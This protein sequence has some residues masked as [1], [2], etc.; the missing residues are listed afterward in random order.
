MMQFAVYWD[1]RIVM[2]VLTRRAKF[3]LL[4]FLI[5]HARFGMALATR[6][7]DTFGILTFFMNMFISTH[8]KIMAI[9]VFKKSTNLRGGPVQCGCH[10]STH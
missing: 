3:A 10:F 2:F 7:N 4:E 1:N 6:A 8:V 5:V 9:A